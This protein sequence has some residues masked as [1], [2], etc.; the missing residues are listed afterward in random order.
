MMN[1][2]LSSKY[3]IICASM[4][5][6]YSYS[7]F[8]ECYRCGIMIGVFYATIPRRDLQKFCQTRN[9]NN[10][11]L[12]ITIKNI[13]DKQI[14]NDILDNNIKFVEVVVGPRGPDGYQH[15]PIIYAGLKLLN[16]S[17]IKIIF[18]RHIVYNELTDAVVIKGNEAASRG[19]ETPLADLINTTRKKYNQVQII[20]S[21]GIYSG[22]Q[23]KHYLESGAAA[24]AVG[25]LFAASK[26]S[27]LSIAAKQQIIKSNS[28]NLEALNTKFSKNMQSLVFSKF[29]DDDGNFTKGLQAGISG[30]RKGHIYAGT[31]IDHITEI[32]PMKSIV[33]ELVRFL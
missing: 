20:A 25:T 14:I 15:D 18:K 10:L 16:S 22:E 24:V 28:T 9:N 26:E 3:P 30:G 1:N 17:G 23:V 7:F 13:L 2:L 4:N 11:V 31:A 33:E 8:E 12:S 5:S 6:V 32:K 19:S 27:P 21:G 29:E